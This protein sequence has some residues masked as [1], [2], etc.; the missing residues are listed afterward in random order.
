MHISNSGCCFLVCHW[1]VRK[2]TR[3]S[4]VLLEWFASFLSFSFAFIGWCFLEVF[5]DFGSCFSVLVDINYFGGVYIF[6]DM[7]LVCLFMML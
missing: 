2:K 4:D 6:I 3:N 7:F 5:S 1:L